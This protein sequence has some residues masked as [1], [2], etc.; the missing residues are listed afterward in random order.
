[1][2]KKI[3]VV[4]SPRIGKILKPAYRFFELEQSSGI[5]LIVVA[6]IAIIWANSPLAASYFSIWNSKVG[7]G[8]GEF[9]I[10][11]DF[12]HWIN[13]GLMAIFFFVVGLEIKRELLIGELSS[14]KNAVL[15]AVAAVGGMVF[16]A[17]IYTM[18]NRTGEASQG[19]GIPMATDI[20]FAIG[21]LSIL[22]N[23]VPFSLKVFLTAV[24]IIDDLGAVIVIAVFYS[25]NI[26]MIMLGLAGIVLLGLILLNF[27][28]VKSPLPYAVLGI[29]LWFLFLK[30]GVH[31]TI[32]GVILAFTIP[33][34]TRIN[35]KDFYDKASEALNEMKENKLVI[36]GDKISPEVNHIIHT[37]EESCEKASA[38]AHRLEHKLHPYVA[39]FIMPVFAL[40]NAGVSLGGVGSG[41]V[42]GVTLGI[43][44]GLFLGKVLG[45]SLFSIASVKLK[46]GVL[47]SGANIRQL[48]GVGFLAGIGF[49]MSL[50]IGSLAFQTQDLLN[51][52]KV[53][54]IAGSLIS[55][56]VGY[57]ILS[58]KR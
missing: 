46:F 26:S 32:A 1:M 33:T 27:L 50:F 53:G 3:Q 25:A 19:W 28:H 9:R 5:L 13:D 51:Y 39:F 35:A 20:A 18:L 21:I 16:P 40:A 47:P 8:F 14:V 17:I 56:I 44:A 55:G 34:K 30:S 2:N 58:R 42:N 31:A 6:I 37:I 7:F 11:K 29:I 43:I 4:E 36:E 10:E 54:I 12:L 49:T 22:G 48:I 41:V 38:P 45:V 57:I 23:K 15:P 52:A 24:A